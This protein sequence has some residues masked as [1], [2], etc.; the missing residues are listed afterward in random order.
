M[1]RNDWHQRLTTTETALGLSDGFR[2]VYGP[3]A[4]FT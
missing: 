1:T 4:V 2:F 3:T